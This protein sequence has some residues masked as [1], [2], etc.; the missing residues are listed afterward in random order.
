[1]SS[2]LAVVVV[3]CVITPPCNFSHY[4]HMNGGM[5]EGFFSFIQALF[6]FYIQPPSVQNLDICAPV[7][8]P[9]LLLQSLI[10][11]LLPLDN[12]TSVS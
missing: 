10:L 9:F 12:S 6:S 2:G 8:E 7:E 11:S 1:M 3:Y 4:F 5:N